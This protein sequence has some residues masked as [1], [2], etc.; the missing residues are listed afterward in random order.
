MGEFPSKAHQWK[1]GQSGN[2]NGRPRGA[3]VVEHLKQELHV[4][5]GQPLESAPA[6]QIAKGLLQI[7]LDPDHPR[8]LDAVDRVMNRIDGPLRQEIAAIIEAPKVIRLKDR[9]EEGEDNT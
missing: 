9:P 8:F 1:P 5:E 4:P 6:R 7:A 2:P 3:S